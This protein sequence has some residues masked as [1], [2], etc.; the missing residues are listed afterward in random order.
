MI[1]NWMFFEFSLFS[2]RFLSLIDLIKEK[3]IFQQNYW[4]LILKLK[5]FS[6]FREKV[7]LYL[8]LLQYYNIYYNIKCVFAFLFVTIE[9]KDSTF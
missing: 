2:F 4:D 3:R 9:S 1:K 7:Y 8:Y 5:I 6:N